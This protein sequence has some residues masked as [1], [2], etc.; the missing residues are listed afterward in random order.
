MKNPQ[1]VAERLYELKGN[2]V[3]ID[4]LL[5]ALIETLPSETLG[6]L[7]RSFEE[8]C[9]IA[10]KTLQDTAISQHVLAAF[11]R[12]CSRVGATLSEVS[13]TPDRPDSIDTAET[14]LFSVTRISTF[15]GSLP[16]SGASG[17]FFRRDRRLFLVTNRH[18]FADQPSQHFPDRFEIDIHTDERDLTKLSVFSIPLHRDGKPLWIQASDVAGPVDVAVIEIDETRLPESA[19][20]QAFDHTHLESLGEQVIIGDT[21]VIIGFPLGFHDTV[22]HLAVA[23]GT[24]IASAY[25]VRF[26]Q[27][28]YFLTDARMHRGSSG[29]PVL[30]RRSEY[31]RDRSA[32]QWQLLGVHSTRMDMRT[33]DLVEDESLGLN[34]AWYAD[35]LMTLTA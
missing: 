30:R 26:Q 22:H 16:L 17:F 13:S 7:T 24:S 12:D 1:E 15:S 5:Q 35:V 28:G 2:L 4:A 3:A 31:A 25:G 33:R 20:I 27:Y 23:R 34:C 10:R 6:V 29:S 14:V 21:L 18:V 32:L 8:R 9:L 19:V 11:E